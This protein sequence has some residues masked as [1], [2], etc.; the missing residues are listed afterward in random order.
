MSV[1]TVKRP[2]LFSA[3]LFDG[4]AAGASK[5]AAIVPSQHSI[6]VS[7]FA[8]GS[9]TGA[10]R[11]GGPIQ[12]VYEVQAQC[13]RDNWNRDGAV[14]I[15]METAAQA[16]T[17]L[18]A[19]P[20]EVPVPEIFADPTGAISFQWYRRPRHRL[21][22]SIYANGIVEFAGLLGVDNEVYGS[23]R[24]GRGLPRIVR[25]HLR[26]LFTEETQAHV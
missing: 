9:A 4:T 19:L 17:L 14:A 10:A 8:G 6:Y 3:W 26:N 25:D 15:S 20:S 16:E 18:L 7:S 5:F 12:T 2:L 23:A 13:S 11:I 21:V 22:L 24:M 1:L